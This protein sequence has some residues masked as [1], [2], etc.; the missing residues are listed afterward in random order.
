MLPGMSRRILVVDDDP[1]ALRLAARLLRPLGAPVETAGSAEAALAALEQAPVGLLLTDLRMDGMDGAALLEAAR[2]RHPHLPVLVMTNHG[3]IEVAVE[4]MKKGATDFITKPLEPSTLLPRIEKL[5]R[6][7]DLEGEV[8]D[9][10]RTLAAQS[11]G[12]GALVG[13]APA[14]RRMLDRLP[15][16]ARADAPVLVRGETGTGKELV[17]RTLHDLS[18]RSDKPFVPVNC[19]ALPG[20]L[21]ESELFGHV[22]GA[23]TDA[24][25]DKAG[26]IA[27]A[28]GGTLFLDEIGDMALALQVK[29]LRFLQEGEIRPVGANKT[30]KVD[31]RVVAATHRDLGAA[32]GEGVF[33]EDLYY[34]LNVV[35]LWVPPLRERR[36]DIPALAGHILARIARRTTRPDLR[37]S[38]GALD[39][40]VRHDWPGNVRELE[41]VIHRAVVFARGP[42]IAED[43]L[44]FD[45]LPTGVPDL[46]P[47][48]VDLGTPLRE[49]K[50]RLVED[51][52]RAYVL[53]ALDS[54]GGNVAQAARRAGKDRKSFWEL[55]QRYGVDADE[56]RE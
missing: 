18:A 44:E 40:L 35:P 15:L 6:T 34:R 41:N 3:S 10:R 32:V 13:E 1:L 47:P 37:F 39:A 55:M 2:A 31:V 7:A 29:L 5:L 19:G 9:L 23:F 48:P 14:F 8:A 22:R 45:A 11:G 38:K 27:E 24:R 52:E 21:L 53:A 56:F 16:A 54:A 46:K 42:E 26:L 33:R 17:A 51:F 43:A 28:D 30:V 49:A 12:R 20:E 50:E 36:G 4:L 25:R